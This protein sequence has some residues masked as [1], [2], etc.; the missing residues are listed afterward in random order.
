[1]EL[2]VRNNSICELTFDTRGKIDEIVEN[3]YELRVR[4]A[5]LHKLTQFYFTSTLN[6]HFKYKNL[7]MKCCMAEQSARTIDSKKRLKTRRESA[8][9]CDVEKISLFFSF[10]SR[11][12][13]RY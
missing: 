4:S 2:R 12:L 6:L 13:S 7:E 9:G 11:P 5:A 1:M 3:V 8:V 10:S